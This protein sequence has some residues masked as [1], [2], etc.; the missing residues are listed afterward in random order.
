[1]TSATILAIKDNMSEAL[2][3]R[4]QQ[5]QF[6]SAA[7]EALLSVAV[8]ANTLNDLMDGICE[9]F[10]ISRPQYNVLRILRGVHPEGH[11][12]CEIARRMIDRASDITRLVDRLQ[13]QGLVKRNRGNSDQREAITRITAKGLRLLDKMQPHIDTQTAAVLHRLND[14]DCRELSRLCALIFE[15]EPEFENTSQTA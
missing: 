15:P 13:A 11:A 8:A 14:E 4:L 1:V 3:R 9:D 12:R 7:Q 10:A 6:A 2:S 5:T